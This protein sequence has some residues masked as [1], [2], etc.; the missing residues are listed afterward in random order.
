LQIIK[1]HTL[2]IN[3]TLLVFALFFSWSSFSQIVNIPDANFKNVLVNL[4]VTDSNGDGSLNADV[5]INNDGEIQN[6]EALLISNLQLPS[7]Q[8]IISLAGLQSFTNLIT[9]SAVYNNI[10]N[11]PML[12]ATQLTDLRLDLNNIT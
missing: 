8:N 2:K 11:V 5:D 4:N 9:F 12:S 1:Y 10:V 3:L 7:F 6:S